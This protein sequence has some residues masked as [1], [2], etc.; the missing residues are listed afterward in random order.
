[1]PAS[2]TIQQRLEAHVNCCV[3]RLGSNLQW[4]FV[5]K[6]KSLRIF[7]FQH[8]ETSSLALHL[9]MPNSSNM[10]FKWNFLQRPHSMQIYW[11]K[12]MTEPFNLGQSVSDVCCYKQLQ[13]HVNGI[14]TKC[15]NISV[16]SIPR[17]ISLDLAAHLI[18]STYLI[19]IRLI[20]EA[21][22]WNHDIN[23]HFCDS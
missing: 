17:S 20:K 13:Y 15:S 7:L 16:N 8:Q 10:W 21:L 19:K 9:M 3:L 2:K 6:E 14:H 22:G 1:M 12:L 5:S 11:G 23:V 4:R 18:Y